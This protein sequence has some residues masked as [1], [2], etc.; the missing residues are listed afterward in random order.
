MARPAIKTRNGSSTLGVETLR[1]LEEAFSYG[2][3]NT[4]ACIQAGLSQSLFYEVCSKNPALSEHFTA[5][6]ETPKVHAIKNI[7]DAIRKGDTKISQWYLERR[8]KSEFALQDAPIES[9]LKPRFNYSE[10]AK[11]R[12]AKYE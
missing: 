10:V 12:M 11:K 5:L 9:E 8:H 2:M 3:N 7:V 1:K 4:Q 6:R